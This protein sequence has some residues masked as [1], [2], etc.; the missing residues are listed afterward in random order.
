MDAIRTLARTGDRGPALALRLALA[1][2]LLLDAARTLEVRSHLGAALLESTGARGFLM[3]AAFLEIAA[4]AALGVGVMT[5]VGSIVPLVLALVSGASALG[6]LGGLGSAGA[7]SEL[8]HAALAGAA[9]IGLIMTG[10]GRWSV[11]ARVLSS[12]RR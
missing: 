11:D 1:A 6:R 5:R 2:D 10:G 8:A 12:G 9:A 4:A 7:L 3:P